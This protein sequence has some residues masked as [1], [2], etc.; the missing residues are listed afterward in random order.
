MY[1]CTASFPLVEFL[2]VLSLTTG[3]SRGMSIISSVLAPL[4]DGTGVMSGV[5]LNFLENGRTLGAS[6][7]DWWARTLIAEG[8]SAGGTV[9]CFLLGFVVSMLLDVSGSQ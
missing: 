4:S 3:L 6:V 1:D 5:E 2:A 7:F 9:L 8:P